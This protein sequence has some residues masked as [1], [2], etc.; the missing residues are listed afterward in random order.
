VAVRWELTFRRR[1]RRPRI[2][3]VEAP[4]LSAAIERARDLHELE[5]Y[6]FSWSRA[7]KST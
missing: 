3:E 6:R 7:L 1:L 4:T 5:G 2:V